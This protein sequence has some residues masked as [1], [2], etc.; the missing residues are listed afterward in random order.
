MSSKGVFFLANDGIYDL[1]VAFLNSF[2][3]HN[4]KS[5]LCLIPFRDDIDRISKLAAKYN[6]TIFDDQ[7]LLAR[8]DEISRKIHGQVIGQ[9]RKFVAWHGPFDQFIYIDADSVVTQDVSFAYDFLE[10]HAF[11]F[12]HSD[13]PYLKRFVWKESID[14]TGVLTQEQINFSA[15]TGYFCSAKGNLPLEEA[16]AK[17][18]GAIGIVDHMV[19]FCVEQPFMNYLVVTS[20]KPYTSLW[21]LAERRS[22]DI[23]FEKWG[24]DHLK[25][26]GME[27]CRTAENRVFMIHWAGVWRPSVLERFAYDVA[28]KL[29]IRLAERPAVRRFM[30][31]RKLWDYYRYMPD[32]VLASRMQGS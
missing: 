12:S 18:A 21:A 5:P 2:R 13:A 19:L 25:L 3:V 7:S 10:D 16:E 4:P 8:C 24:G 30:P 6:F 17:V 1:S 15:N 14:A 23:P 9:Y 11:I 32:D 22:I 31:N 27:Y 20:G 29:G 26:Q 28:H